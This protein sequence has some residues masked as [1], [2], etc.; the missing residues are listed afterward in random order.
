MQQRVS[1]GPE[2]TATQTRTQPSM[3]TKAKN[4]QRSDQEE[5]IYLPGENLRPPRS[6]A[7]SR[8]PHRNKEAL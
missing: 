4:K 7:S 3:E 8:R 2:P 1:K 6:L 5:G